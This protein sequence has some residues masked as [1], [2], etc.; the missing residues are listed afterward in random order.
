MSALQGVFVTVA[1]GALAA[2]VCRVIQLALKRRGVGNGLAIAITVVA[3]VLVIGSLVAA[4]VASVI[5]LSAEL[6]KDSGRLTEA[7]RQLA[8]QFGIVVGLPPTEI[9]QIDIEQLVSAARS[10]LAAVTPAVT[11]LAMAVLIVTYLLLGADGLRARMLGTTSQD[12]IDRYDAL[13][14]ELVVYVKVRAS[15]GGAAAIADTVLLLVLGVPYAVLWG[16]VSFLFSF[17]PNIGFVIALIPPTILAFLDGGIVPAVAVVGGYVAINLAFDYVLQPRMLSISLDLSPVVTIVSI[18]AW[19]AVVGPMG[20]LLAVPLTIAMRTI[21]MPFPGLTGSWRSWARYPARS[22]RTSR[23]SRPWQRRPAASRVAR[24]RPSRE[25]P[26]LPPFHGRRP[27]GRGQRPWLHDRRRRGARVPR[28]GGGRRRRRHRT[29]P[30]GGRGRRG[31]PLGTLAYAHGSAF[32]TEPLERYAERLGPRLPMADPA[33]YPVSGGS[34]AIETALKLA[35]ATQL[36]RGEKDRDVVIARWGSYHG[37]SLGALDL[38]GRRPLRAPYEA[39]LGRF[40]HVSAAYPYRAHVPGSQAMDDPRALAAELEVAIQRAG[41]GRVAA[42]VAEPIVGATLGAVEPPV[43][44]WPAIADVCRR[45]GVLLVADEVMTGFGRAGTWFA[46]D[47]YG[48]APDLL[49]AAKGATSGYW[50]FGFVA[51][52]G[53]VWETVTRGGGFVHGFTYSHQPGGAAV[54]LEVL[55]ILEEERLVETSASKGSGSWGS[56]GRASATTRTSATSGASGSS[57]AWSSSGTARPRRRSPARSGSSR[58]VSGSPATG[59]CS[60][61]RG[62][63]TRTAS[64]AMS[65]CWGRRSWSRTAN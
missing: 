26:G 57:P 38:S 2:I 6:T 25:W 16:I 47:R 55:R 34:E 18:L 14:A 5:A 13:A 15:L 12:V 49:V 17:V 51:A 36:A 46:M 65:S 52:S 30:T 58:R 60:S 1:F 33:I 27:A 11:G 35:R 24:R 32:T 63:A 10:L 61:T 4:L 54:A 3:F 31:G 45:H 43:G 64:T 9:P 21:L 22:P 50:P 29:R 20:A 44:Y 40:R 19:T 62:R 7:L 56:S 59:G 8:D 23:R 37:N 28:R 42:F 39:W 41:E 53:E 48:V